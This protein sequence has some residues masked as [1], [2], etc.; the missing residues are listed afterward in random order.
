MMSRR[1]ALI[2][3]AV[4]ALSL[5]PCVT[6]VVQARKHKHQARKADDKDSQARKADDKDSQA[7]KT[8]DKN[9]QALKDANEDDSNSAA[10]QAAIVPVAPPIEHSLRVCNGYAAKKPLVVA[11]ESATVTKDPIDYK[12]CADL[13]MQ[14]K[15]D[16]ELF[17]KVGDDQ[18]GAFTASGLP[19][20]KSPLLLV[21]YRRGAN[22]KSAAFESHIYADSPLAQMAIIDTYGGDAENT[23][24]IRRGWKGKLEPLTFGSIAFINPGDYD[25]SLTGEGGSQGG[26]TAMFSKGITRS[27]NVTIQP[28][29]SYVAMRVGLEGNHDFPEELVM[30]GGAAAASL[31]AVALLA[32]SVLASLFRIF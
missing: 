17:F 24:Q 29:T 6:E 12:K 5:T 14:L 31:S 25:I 18:V 11:E 9:S 26:P 27:M 8:D 10:E 7:R 19:E 16:D 13:T 2:A 20:S 30:L 22:L 28:A 3:V 21:V 15:E 32:T 1:A 4:A 23:V